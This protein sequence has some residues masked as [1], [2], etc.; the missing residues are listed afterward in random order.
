MTFHISFKHPTARDR[1]GYDPAVVGDPFLWFLGSF[2]DW[3]YL[4]TQLSLFPVS[5]APTAS[6]SL[7]A[8]DSGGLANHTDE[9]RIDFGVFRLQDMST[10]LKLPNRRV[11]ACTVGQSSIP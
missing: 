2:A 9:D 10:L 8:S 5:S 6:Q 7:A 4:G 1:W 11:K 3:C